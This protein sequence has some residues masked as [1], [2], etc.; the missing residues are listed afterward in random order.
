MAPEDSA[1]SVP[2]SEPGGDRVEAALATIWCDVLNLTEVDPDDN[3]FDRGGYSLRAIQ[4]VCAIY[5]VMG[6]EVPL[7]TIWDYPTFKRLADALR[8]Y[9]PRQTPSSSIAPKRL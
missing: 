2:S 4:V 5:E 8:H 3:F 7:R 1:V 6:V 9:E